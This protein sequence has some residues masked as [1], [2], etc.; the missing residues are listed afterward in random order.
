[1]EPVC[2]LHQY[3]THI[4]LYRRE[5]LAEIVHLLWLIILGFLLLR[6]DTYK[7]SHIIPE[8]FTDVINSVRTIFHNIVQ[9]CSHNRV[10]SQFQLFCH[11]ACHGN[12]MTDI[13]FTRL[14]QLVFVGKSG[15]AVCI[16]QQVHLVLVN[17]SSHQCEDCVHIGLY[18]LFVISLHNLIPFSYFSRV[19]YF[20][21]VIEWE[22][23]TILS[24]K[25]L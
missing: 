5:N 1:M 24:R 22:E 17:S 12:R 23:V 4:I 7:K 21:Y 16:V 14:A 3:G 25:N 10:C 8:T 19:E 18:F 13:G 20:F 2:Q 15:E 11:N 6:H 9:E